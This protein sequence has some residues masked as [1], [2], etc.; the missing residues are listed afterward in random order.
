MT[1]AA[2]SFPWTVVI[3]ALPYGVAT[4]RKY[5][6]YRFENAATLPALT[7]PTLL[8]HGTADGL[9][10]FQHHVDLARAVV[11]TRGSNA[12]DCPDC[13][14]APFVGAGYAECTQEMPRRCPGDAQKM[15]RRCPGDA[16]EMPTR[17][18]RDAQD[19]A[20]FFD[21][22]LAMFLAP[23]LAP[24]PPCHEHN[25]HVH[26]SISR[27]HPATWISSS[28]QPYSRCSGRT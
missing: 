26:R 18:P 14:F 24:C 15:P 23:R 27:A 1:E 9:V 22:S 13:R 6:A 17:C 19:C 28:S 21:E 3:R 16:Q 11:A 2:V 10:P 20:H 25:S 7:T 4:I 8:L 12:P 5:F